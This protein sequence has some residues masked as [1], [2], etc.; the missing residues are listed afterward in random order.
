MGGTLYF[1]HG[2]GVRQDGF[3]NTMALIRNGIKPLLPRDVAVEGRCWGSEL[4]VGLD[5]EG[6]AKVLPVTA[7]KG[8]E[9]DAPSDAEIEAAIWSELLDDPLFELRL[10]VGIGASA[11]TPPP[12]PQI[13]PGQKAEAMFLGMRDRLADP[14]PGGIPA[15]ELIEAAD[16]LDQTVIT[17]AAKS[18]ADAAEPGFTTAAARCLVASV[19]FRRRFAAPGTAPAACYSKEERERLVSEVDRAL[20]GGA[21]QGSSREAR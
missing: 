15:L 11:A 10:A 7:T 6:L 9:V 16:Q 8:T 3:N 4:G 14:L 21:A 20:S 1:V 13:L 5:E 2:T 18:F 12:F 19:L 17:A